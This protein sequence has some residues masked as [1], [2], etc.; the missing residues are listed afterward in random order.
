MPVHKALRP[1]GRPAFGKVPRALD[2]KATV[3]PHSSR[4]LDFSAN[5]PTEQRRTRGV[6]TSAR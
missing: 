5:P 2:S 3:L 4:T 1:E 6:A